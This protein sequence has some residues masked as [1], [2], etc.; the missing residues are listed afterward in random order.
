MDE[1]P[2]PQRPDD[3]SVLHALKVC[4][5]MTALYTPSLMNSGAYTSARQ[6]I[7]ELEPGVAQSWASQFPLEAK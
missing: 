5:E 4:I 7:A 6:I 3:S 2:L 1:P